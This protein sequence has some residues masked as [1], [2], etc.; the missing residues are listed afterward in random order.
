MQKNKILSE[1]VKVSNVLPATFVPQEA[2]PTQIDAVMNEL[3][4]LEIL[5]GVMPTQVI[6]D[7]AVD[8]QPMSARERMQARLQE[9]RKKDSRLVK[10]IFRFYEVPNGKLEFVHCE[11]PGDRVETYRLKDGTIYEIPLGVAKHLNK[12]GSYPIHERVM[13]D[14]GMVEERSVKKVRRFGFQSLDFVDESDF[15]SKDVIAIQYETG[16]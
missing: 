12:N 4:E 3:D 9:M 6:L 13:N 8:A 16:R 1:D 7:D 15:Q 2:G 14:G 11:Y 10:G 5:D